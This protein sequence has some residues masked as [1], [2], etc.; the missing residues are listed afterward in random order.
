V[1]SFLLQFRAMSQVVDQAEIIKLLIEA[2]GTS[3]IRHLNLAM[4]SKMIFRKLN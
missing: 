3:S 1:E 2:L 4:A